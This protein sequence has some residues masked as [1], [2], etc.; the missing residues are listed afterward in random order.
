VKKLA[1]VGGGAAVVAMMGASMATPTGWL[2]VLAGSIAG[3]AKSLKILDAKRRV[4]HASQQA[5]SY[6]CCHS[7][8]RDIFGSDLFPPASPSLPA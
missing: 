2:A 6:L 4:L 3:N 5:G 1:I 8:G 7:C